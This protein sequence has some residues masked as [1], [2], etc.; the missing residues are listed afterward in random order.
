[1]KE[2]LRKGKQTK[3]EVHLVRPVTI[4]E[5]KKIFMKKKALYMPESTYERLAKTTK[6]LISKKKIKI[7]FEK[8]PGR[9]IDKSPDHLHR[10][11][12]LYKSGISLRN[13]EKKTALPKSSV[14]YLVKKA[15]RKKVKNKSNIYSLD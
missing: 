12:S 7:V 6:N 1:M 9:P 11:I 2:V 15:K 5:F 8:I 10:A 4:K 13:I 14:H 3:D